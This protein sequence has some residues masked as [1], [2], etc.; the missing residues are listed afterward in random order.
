VERFRCIETGEEVAVK[1]F[2]EVSR[3]RSASEIQNSFIR[4]VTSLINLSHPCVLSLRGCSLPSGGRPPRI[5]TEFLGGGTLKDVL[6]VSGDRFDWW[7]ST[8][9]AITIAGIISGMKYIHSQGII[10]RDLKPSNILFDQY[11]EVKI[12]DVGS[13][14]FYDTDVTLTGLMGTPLY[15]APEMGGRN[16][17]FKVD[18]YS[19]GIIVYEI[20]VGDGLF[21]GVESNKLEL[22]AMM[23]NGK[24]P[25]IPSSVC[26]FARDLISKCWSHKAGD[27]PSFSDIL[28]FLE[29]SDFK[30][31]PDVNS[32]EVQY[33]VEWVG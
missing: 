28:A 21:S 24:R 4:E 32:R 29:K 17:D 27:R 23:Q 12:G 33:Y 7:T 22:L 10:H 25:K 2:P 11:H 13:S 31:F 1:S 8:Q 3:E 18:V 15:M 9:K 5:V 16:Y 20:V 19:F 6:S 14:R 26:R 30:I